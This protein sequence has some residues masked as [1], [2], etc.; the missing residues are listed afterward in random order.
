M[1][2]RAAP[3]IP[4]PVKGGRGILEEAFGMN[5]SP[6]IWSGKVLTNLMTLLMVFIIGLIAIKSLIF[7]LRRKRIGYLLA[8]FKAI[9]VLFGFSYFLF[10]GFYVFQNMLTS[11]TSEDW[12]RNAVIT[13][14]I[15]LVGIMCWLGPVRG[16]LGL[17]VQK[18]HVRTEQSNASADG[19]VVESWLGEGSGFHLY[20]VG[21]KKSESNKEWGG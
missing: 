14:V 20:A 13:F 7:L 21:E 11:E 12:L 18:A 16:I 9:W 8:G 17:S 5:V 2:H 1:G 4:P 3:T 6:L 19:W 15:L 10:I